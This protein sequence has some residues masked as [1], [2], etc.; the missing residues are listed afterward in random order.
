[1]PKFQDLTG[2]K[3]GELTVIKMLKNY[4][5]TRHVYCICV[6]ENGN[7]CPRPIRADALTRGVTKHAKGAGRTGRAFDITGRKFGLLTAICPTSQRE[8]NGNIVW[9]C[10]CDCGNYTFVGVSSLLSGHTL[11]CGCRHRSK[12]EVYICDILSKHCVEYEWEKCFID[13]TNINETSTLPFD[14]YLP[15]Y[16]SIIE[17]DGLQHFE[18]IKLW[19][20]D[21]KLEITK[22]NDNIKDE[23][24]RANHINLLRIPYTTKKEDIERIILE[25]LQSAT[26]TVT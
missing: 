8:S 16:N 24:C 4:N 15:K 11:S 17:Y 23:Y 7:E 9:S 2:N 5:N 14:F 22:Q 3:Y 26:T 12:W 25:F 19:G 1:M 20:G 10:L 13:C 21:E 18:S 6:D